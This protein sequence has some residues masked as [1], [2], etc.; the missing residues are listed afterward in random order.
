[1]ERKELARIVHACHAE[2]SSGHNLA[3]QER[4]DVVERKELARIVLACHADLSSGLN[5]AVQEHGDEKFS[6]F[7]GKE[8]LSSDQC[9]DI[10]NYTFLYKYFVYRKVGCVKLNELH[11]S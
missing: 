11:L 3:V 8:C 6:A 10:G 1:M 9:E 5:L 7:T 2:L 4:G